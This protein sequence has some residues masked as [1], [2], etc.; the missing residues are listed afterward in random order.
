MENKIIKLN[1]EYTSRV[2]TND[3]LFLQYEFPELEVGRIGTS[4]LGENIPFLKL[5]K[6]QYKVM[7]N[8]SHHANEWMTS[9]IV[10]LFVE[11]Y[12]WLH[13]QKKNYKTYDCNDI[14]NKTSLYIVPMVNPDG[15]NLSLQENRVLHEMEYCKL[16]EN[17]GKDF[18]KRWKANIRGVDL[19]LNYP[20]GWEIARKNK[21]KKGVTKPGPRD[22]V[23]PNPLSEKETIAMYQFTKI[24]SFDLTISLHSQGKEIYGNGKKNAKAKKL[25]KLFET[26]SGY[27]YTEPEYASSFAGYKDWFVSTYSKPGFT[28]EIGKGEEGVCLPLEQAKEIYEEIEEI[29]FIALD[30]VDEA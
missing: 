13:K 2:L 14:W 15:V 5:G 23:G 9:L 22:Y 18:F 16:W 4:L 28:I 20:A 19:N 1:Q 27:H 17:K 7:I 24:H 21:E 3:I 12:L 6:G 30:E 11:K 26:V 10:M 29:F 25:A 8:A